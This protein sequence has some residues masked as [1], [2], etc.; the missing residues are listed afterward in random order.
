MLRY[1]VDGMT[2]GHCVQ[3]VTKAVK[4]ADPAAE[5]SVDLPTKKVEVTTS[6]DRSHVA[7]AIREAGYTPQE[8]T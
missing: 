6:A 1:Q 5:V 7:A 2:C 8:L 4:A 3:A